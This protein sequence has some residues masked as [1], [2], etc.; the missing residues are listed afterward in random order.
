MLT[1]GEADALMAM[2]K[3]RK[4]DESYDFPLPGETLTIPNISDEMNEKSF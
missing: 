3:K 4:S 2:P 1:Q